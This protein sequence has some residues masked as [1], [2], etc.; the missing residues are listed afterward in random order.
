MSLGLGLNFYVPDRECFITNLVEYVRGNL[1]TDGNVRIKQDSDSLFIGY[2]TMNARI[3]A[4]IYGIKNK[5]NQGENG[6]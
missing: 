6:H 1:A 4:V 5:E 3:K 2:E